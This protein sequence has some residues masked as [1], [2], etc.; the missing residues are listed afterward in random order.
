MRLAKKALK[1]IES[2]IKKLD[3][4]LVVI[5]SLVILMVTY[6]LL[7]LIGLNPY[8]G[9]IPSVVYLFSSIIIIDRLDNL[10]KV[11]NKYSGLKHELTTARD[12]QDKENIVLDSLE[13]EILER[14]R[15]TKVSDFFPYKR[16]MIF[17]IILI[18]SVTFSLIIA[19]NDIKVLDFDNL[20]QEAIKNMEKQNNESQEE[21]NFISGETSIMEV[22]NERIEVEINPVGMDLDFNE[23]EEDSSYEFSVSFPKDVSPEIKL[24]SS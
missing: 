23:V 2:S 16:T 12:Y 4:F 13:N 6:F 7:F 21:I 5:N 8:Y 18:L 15:K 17:T 11:E 9:I 19:S 1:E 3:I 14:L 22:G 24:I 20:V 10:K